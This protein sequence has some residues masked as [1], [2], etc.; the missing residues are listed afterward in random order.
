MTVELGENFGR[1]VLSSAAVVFGVLGVALLFAGAETSEALLGAPAPE[2]LPALV[3]SALFG[4]A[5]LDWTAR[6][7]PLGGIYGRPIVV[8]NWVHFLA[9]ALVLSKHS[10]AAGGGALYALTGVYVTGAVLFGWLLFGRL[11]PSS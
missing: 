11:R 4:F 8:G 2:P 6:G 1:W 7:S 9:G 3:G 5:A 10:S